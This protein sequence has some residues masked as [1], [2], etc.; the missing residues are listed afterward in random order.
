MKW[1]A[2]LLSLY[3]ILLSCVPCAACGDC[4]EDEIAQTD[5][6]NNTQDKHTESDHKTDGVCS[7]FFACGTCH[8]AVVSGISLEF[9]QS[10]PIA[11]VTQQ[12]F[13][14]DQPLPDYSPVIWQPPKAA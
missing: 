9:P 3:V 11:T 4:C 14:S 2:C 5:A 6:H 8:G 10:A 7:P 13:Y 12:F 1:L